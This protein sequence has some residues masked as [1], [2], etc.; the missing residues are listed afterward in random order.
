MAETEQLEGE[1]VIRD[2]GGMGES[3]RGVL[4]GGVGNRGKAD[5]IRTELT[6]FEGVQWTALLGVFRA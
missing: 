4:T 5:I 6:H 1:G 2:R 3:T